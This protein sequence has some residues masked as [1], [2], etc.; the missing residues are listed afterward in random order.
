[1]QLTA[2]LLKQYLRPEKSME[3]WE[4]KEEKMVESIT[5]GFCIEKN[6][7]QRSKCCFSVYLESTFFD[8]RGPLNCGNFWGKI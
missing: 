1:M 4:G 2:L 6:G 5:E 3:G 8:Y 7:F